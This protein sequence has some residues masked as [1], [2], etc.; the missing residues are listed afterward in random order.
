MG[1]TVMYP[2]KVNVFVEMKLFENVVY[3]SVNFVQSY[4]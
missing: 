4:L 1:K 2:P 3:L